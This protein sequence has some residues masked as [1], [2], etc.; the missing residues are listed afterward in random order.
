MNKAA[1]KINAMSPDEV[2]EKLL[3]DL[4]YDEPKHYLKRVK[5]RMKIYKKAYQL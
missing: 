5:K 3:K 4:K 2:Y 1:P